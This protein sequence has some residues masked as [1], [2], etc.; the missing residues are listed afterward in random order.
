[1]N[2]Q[3]Q[4][5]RMEEFLAYVKQTAFACS[6]ERAGKSDFQVPE[7]LPITTPTPP[8][9]AKNVKLLRELQVSNSLV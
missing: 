2:F 3:L 9:L 1:M 5:K 8:L 4:Q 6:P 7:C